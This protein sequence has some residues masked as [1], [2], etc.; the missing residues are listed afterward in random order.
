MEKFSPL[1]TIVRPF[2]QLLAY[3]IWIGTEIGLPREKINRMLS[4]VFVDFA[5]GLVPLVGD[6]A[7]FAYKAN[8]RNLLL[9]EEAPPLNV[10]EGKLA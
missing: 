10:I 3:I 4:H 7:D 5:L 2:A 9:L 8:S 1:G 6:M